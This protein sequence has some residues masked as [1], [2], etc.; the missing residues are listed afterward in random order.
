[1]AA[2]GIRQLDCDVRMAEEAE[3]NVLVPPVVNAVNA[4]QVVIATGW[5]RE[6][7]L[8][9]PTASAVAVPMECTAAVTE[10]VAAGERPKGPMRKRRSKRFERA[11]THWKCSFCGKEAPVAEEATSCGHCGG[12]RVQLRDADAEAREMARLK[13]RVKSVHGRRLNPQARAGYA[14]CRDQVL[15]HTIE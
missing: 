2:A 4:L 9:L 15:F 1:M 5:V 6:A 8:S 10:S 14:Q 3:M 7:D 13:G 11:C 12:D